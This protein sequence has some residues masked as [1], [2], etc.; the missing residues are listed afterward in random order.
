MGLFRGMA[1]DPVT[2]SQI[3]AGVPE[4]STW[5]MM[6]LGFAGLGF[7]SLR[8]RYSPQR[9]S[10]NLAGSSLLRPPR[11]HRLSFSLRRVIATREEKPMHGAKFVPLTGERSGCLS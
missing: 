9:R 2:G 4:P 3:V 10:T 1:K 11:R 7:A 6:L 5:T 8:R